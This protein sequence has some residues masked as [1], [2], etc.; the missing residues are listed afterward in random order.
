MISACD[1]REIEMQSI[2]IQN[3]DTLDLPD[4]TLK[5]LQL[6]NSHLLHVVS[7]RLRRTQPSVT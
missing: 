1:H 4:A 3:A 7:M 2:C 6:K 5:C